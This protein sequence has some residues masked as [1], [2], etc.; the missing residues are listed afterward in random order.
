MHEPPAPVTINEQR[1]FDA[2]IRSISSWTSRDIATYTSQHTNSAAFT[3]NIERCMCH[4]QRMPVPL[5]KYACRFELS[6]YFFFLLTLKDR[7]G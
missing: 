1:V 5:Y 6:D 2:W 7:E 4:P 3:H